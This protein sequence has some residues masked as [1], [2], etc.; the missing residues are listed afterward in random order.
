M[1]PLLLVR[2]FFLA[3][4]GMAEILWRDWKGGH[5]K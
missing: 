4:L 3:L 5:E 1:R 2:L